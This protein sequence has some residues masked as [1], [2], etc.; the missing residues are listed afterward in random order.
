MHSCGPS[1]GKSST[2][3]H[4][5]RP[6]CV[7]SVIQT[8]S[9]A[10]LQQLRRAKVTS[11]LS[12]DARP[13]AG[14]ETYAA[15]RQGGTTELALSLGK[16]TP[17]MRQPRGRGGDECCVPAFEL[18]VAVTIHDSKETKSKDNC[19]F[20]ANRASRSPRP[21]SYGSPLT[22]ALPV[23]AATKPHRVWT[24]DQRRLPSS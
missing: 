20:V 16:L 14:G 19:V 15:G 8:P 11:Q 13:R 7:I 24:P 5:H 12:Q 6:T 21:C 17:Q 3:A 4:I 1:L 10:V 22:S 2:T 18:L 23:H 9:S